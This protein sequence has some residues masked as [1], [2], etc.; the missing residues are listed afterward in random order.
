[1]F[2]E[3]FHVSGRELMEGFKPDLSKQ[4]SLQELSAIGYDF[5]TMDAA[6]SGPALQSGFLDP[7]FLTTEFGGVIRQPVSRLSLIHI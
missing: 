6:L 2:K 4:W 1:M 3:N 5:S 7:K